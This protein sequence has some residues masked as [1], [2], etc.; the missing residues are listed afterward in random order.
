VN[1]HVAAMWIV[2]DTIAPNSRI[3]PHDLTDCKM[4]SKIILHVFLLSLLFIF[5]PYNQN[6][7]CASYL[8]YL[9]PSFSNDCYHNPDVD[10]NIVSKT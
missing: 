7:S 8:G 4:A 9:F 3:L 2:L 1:I 10:N 6:N 5:I